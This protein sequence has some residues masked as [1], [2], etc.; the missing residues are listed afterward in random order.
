MQLYGINK[1]PFD[2]KDGDYKSRHIFSFIMYNLF[3]SE[4]RGLS[5]AK[6]QCHRVKKK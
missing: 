6:A 5:H 3:T 4:P 2:E 1:K